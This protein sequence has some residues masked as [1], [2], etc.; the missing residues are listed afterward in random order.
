M[1]KILAIGASNSS[2]SINTLFTTYLSNQIENTHVIPICCDDLVLPFYSADLEVSE[3]IPKNVKHF[4]NFVQL[5]DAIVLIGTK[6]PMGNTN[7]R[8]LWCLNGIEYGVI[9]R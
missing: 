2:K 3:G 8:Y 9:T 4:R 7:F 5:V 1:K 6:K